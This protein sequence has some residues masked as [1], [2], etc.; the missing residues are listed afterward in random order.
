MTET[1]IRTHLVRLARKH[2][3]A[4][5]I[6]GAAYTLLD[7][8]HLP[9]DFGVHIEAVEPVGRA[10]K[11]TLAMASRAGRRTRLAELLAN[12]ELELG[13]EIA[14]SLDETPRPLTGP[15]DIVHWT[16]DGPYTRIQHWVL[17]RFFALAQFDTLP[18]ALARRTRLPSPFP[19]APRHPF[20]TPRA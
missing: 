2:G 11:T 8:D 3:G 17:S 12:G 20:V 6:Y 19:R 15:V 7:D 1:E 14:C 18:E 16:L 4:N 10:V 9:E 5:L 13:T